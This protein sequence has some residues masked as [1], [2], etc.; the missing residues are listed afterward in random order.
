MT[1]KILK[2][3]DGQVIIILVLIMLVVLAVGLSIAQRST[4]NVAISTVTENTSRAFAAAEAGV[5]R[6]LLNN[7]VSNNCIGFFISPPEFGNG[8]EARVIC[9]TPPAAVSGIIPGPRGVLGV[10]QINKTQFAQVWLA[11]PAFSPPSTHY[12]KTRF[13]IAFGNSP[14]LKAINPNIVLGSDARPAIEVNVI[15]LSGGNYISNKY[16]YDSVSVGGDSF[17]DATCNSA[18]IDISVPAGLSQIGPG[19]ITN[20][21]ID[22]PW[23]YCWTPVSVV[24]T[25]ILARARLLYP[26]SPNPQY[27]DSSQALVFI[28]AAFNNVINGP[29]CVSSNSWQGCSFPPQTMVFESIGTAGETRRKLKVRSTRN[30]VPHI[31][32]FAIFSAVDLNK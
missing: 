22:S 18:G 24:G 9:P 27:T 3:Q 19:Y 6:A 5:E 17:N 4:T 1:K 21:S 26:N 16:Y 23:F 7:S 31:L 25:P 14:Q 13:A 11:D 32:D 30:V 28:P 29:D 8:S 15:S 2:N 10:G 20:V 12:Q